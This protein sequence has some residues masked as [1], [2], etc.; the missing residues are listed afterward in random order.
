MKSPLVTIVTPSYNQGH[1]IAATI[2]SVLTQDYPHIEY[3]IMDGASTDGTAEAVRPY[4]DRLTFISEKDRG[5]THAINKGLRRAKGEIVAYLNSD[6]TLLPGA[7]SRAVAALEAHPEAGAIYGDGFQIDYDGNVKQKFPFTEPFNLWKLTFV[8]DYVLQQSVFF[9]RRC[10]ESVGW[11]N[12]ELHF[13]MDWDILVRLGKQYGLVYIPETL[14]CL[15]EYD[16]AKS[17]AGGAKRFAELS[18]LL[19][20]QTGEPY[21]PGWWFYGLDTY[22]KIWSERI[23][24]WAPGPLG[25]YV[26]MR[27]VH[28]C[29]YVIDREQ[30]HSQ[31]LYADG[32]AADTLH[33][34]MPACYRRAV[35]RGSIPDWAP[36]L[37]RQRLRVYV[38]GELAAEHAPGP[39]EFTIPLDLHGPG[40]PRATVLR[41]EAELGVV[42]SREGV[43][44]DGR[45]LSWRLLGVDGLR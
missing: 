33:W 18:R 40:P 37:R 29:R 38:N 41:V 8:L 15:R 4:A 23:R 44:H 12:E 43:G 5:Q 10:V 14:G 20:A 31:G 26:A 1:F 32:W 6:D 35:V 11:F 19:R 27:T 30:H 28:V 42:P 7:V 16:A 3:I 39:G 22:D 2:E 24:R 17:F 34:M 9:R 25:R 36:G 45:R 13:G 21:P